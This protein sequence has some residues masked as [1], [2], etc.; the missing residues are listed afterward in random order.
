VANF[1][2]A[3]MQRIE[4][5]WTSIEQ[6]IRLADETVAG[7]GFTGKTLASTNAVIPIVYYLFL[8]GSPPGFAQSAAFADDRHAVQRWLNIVLL[9]RTF[10]GVPD[11]V[12]RRMRDII[13]EHHNEFPIDVI[14][15]ELEPTR[16]NLS[17][18]ESELESLL[19]GRYGGQY[20]FPLLAMLYPSLDFRHKLHQD[21]IHPKSHFTPSQLKKRGISEELHEQYI[22]RCDLIPNL[23]LLEGQPNIEKS[24]TS[25]EEWLPVT[26][27]DPI[28]R[29]D[30]QTRH[31]IP[32]TE[33]SLDGFPHFFAERRKLLLDALRQLVGIDTSGEA[34]EDTGSATVGDTAGFNLECMKRVNE[35]LSDDFKKNTQALYEAESNKR[36][37]CLVSKRYARGQHRYWFAFRPHHVDYLRAAAAAWVILGCGDADL[38][39]VIPAD[40]F[41]PALAGMRQTH[42][43]DRSYWHVECFGDASRLEL[44]QSLVGGRSDVTRFVLP[45]RP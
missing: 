44:G 20:T 30:Y 17:F 33:Y 10:G 18:R 40:V 7:F 42:D 16:F 9:R 39:V 8:R 6:A 23:Q 12:L 24:A 5:L 4:G 36:A 15:A 2:Q 27:P 29:S 35:H 25:F 19:D 3:S 22:G 11:D 37:V 13:R 1:N 26:F 41:L 32:A 28:R 45:R 31:F 21:H 38:T 43:G 34:E 14:A